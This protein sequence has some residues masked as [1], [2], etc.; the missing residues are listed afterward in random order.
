MQGIEI[1]LGAPLDQLIKDFGGAEKLV[2]KF[3]DQVNDSLGKTGTGVKSATKDFTGLSR[4]IQDLPFGFI[5]IQNNITQLL[6]A[7]GALGLGISVLVSAVT[8]AQ[9]GFSNWTRG[10]VDT[11]KA[12]DDAKLSG[13]DYLATLD[14]ISQAS[15][16]GTQS[17]QSELTNLQLLYKQYTD[18]NNS[19]DQRKSAYS[20]LQNLYPAYFGNLEFEQKATGA[21]EKAYKTLTD[22]I[23]A[24]AKARAF[25]DKIAENSIRKLE[26]EQKATDL[27]V[28]QDDLVS[29]GLE[30][31]RKNQEAL[32]ATYNEQQKQFKL[33]EEQIKVNLDA[34]EKRIR[35]SAEFIRL[36][37]QINNLNTDS[38]K[39]TEKNIALEKQV[40]GQTAAGGLLTGGVGGKGGGQIAKAQQQQFDRDKQ[41]SI[42]RLNSLDAFLLKYRETESQINR[43]P[44]IPI[45]SLTQTLTQP[46]ETFQSN[47]LPQLQSSFQNFFDEIL[48]RG[49]LSFESLGKSILNTFASVLANQATTGLLALLGDKA[50]QAKASTGIIGGIA[51]LFKGGDTAKGLGKFLGKALPVAGIALGAA[52]VLGGLFKKKESVPIPAQSNIIG[53]SSSGSFSSSFSPTEVVFRIQGNDLLGVLNRAQA[54]NRR[55]GP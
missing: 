24:T 43:T 20:Q 11:K 33:S 6:P 39:I 3:K 4:V 41:I 7:A 45:E 5:G 42:Q 18:N 46:I 13:D 19:L 26:N 9:T 51:S 55:F 44:L 22:S 48:I 36:Q 2:K 12:V 17:A 49:K 47:I 50:S 35:N 38:N 52:S 1:P 53:T 14:Q 21:T 10:L 27:K 37:Q 8:F 32:N 54:R 16:R 25:S 34:E 28:K 29:K 40:Q 23:I 15:L 31:S 30:R